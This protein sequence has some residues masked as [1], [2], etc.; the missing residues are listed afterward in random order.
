MPNRTQ[1]AL[2][3][4]I[5]NTIRLNDRSSSTQPVQ[6]PGVILRFWARMG[7]AALNRIGKER[8]RYVCVSCIEI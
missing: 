8:L 2:K 4:S 6:P 7:T 5:T 1:V 3:T